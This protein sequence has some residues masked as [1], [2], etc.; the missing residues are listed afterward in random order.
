VLY[1]RAE[2]LKTSALGERGE[3]EDCLF[4]FHISRLTEMT[5]RVNPASAIISNILEIWLTVWGGELI[6][7]P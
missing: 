3:P 7:P 2:R 6:L 1:Q 5:R 4:V